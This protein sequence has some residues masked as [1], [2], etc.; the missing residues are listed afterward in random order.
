[1]AAKSEE[2]H[3]KQIIK[4]KYYTSFTLDL[5]GSKKTQA[6]RGIDAFTLE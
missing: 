2:N 6:S 4:D 5:K 3:E 1:M